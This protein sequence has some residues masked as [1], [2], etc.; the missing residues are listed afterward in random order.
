MRIL[1]SSV[2]FMLAIGLLC[3]SCSGRS[4]AQASLNISLRN[5]TAV[6][7]D[8]VELVWDGPQVPGGILS[9]GISSTAL[10]CP[11]PSSDT[12]KVKF[13]EKESRKPHSIELNVAVLKALSAG[14]H[15]VVLSI[16]A[17]EQGRVIVDG[18]P[19]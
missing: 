9:P 3:A 8:W 4:K 15:E 6:A 11:A 16:T 19:K 2:G 5:D 12:A 13:V 17:L 1:L 7:L 10:D 18:Q 14:K